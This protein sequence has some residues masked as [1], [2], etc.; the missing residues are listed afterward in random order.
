MMLNKDVGDTRLP[1]IQLIK[2]QSLL[3]SHQSR[4]SLLEQLNQ[5]FAPKTLGLMTLCPDET[6]RGL[7]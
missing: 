7:E 2:C 6:R 1:W 3:S 4:G 5:E